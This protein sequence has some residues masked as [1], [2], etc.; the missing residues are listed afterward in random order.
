MT[1]PPEFPK[2]PDAG[3]GKQR[4]SNQVKPLLRMLPESWLSRPSHTRLGRWLR[5]TVLVWF[6][7]VNR[8]GCPVV[9]VVIALSDHPLARRPCP[10]GISQTRLPTARFRVSKVA[11]P[12][13]HARQSAIWARGN[14]LD[15]HASDSV[16]PNVYS[17]CRLSPRLVC[18][19]YR[20]MSCSEEVL[21]A[22]VAQYTT[23][24]FGQGL[25]FVAQN[26][27]LLGRHC[28]RSVRTGNRCPLDPK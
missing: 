18:R 14:R 22:L 21:P 12:L 6:G 2:K 13:S 16:L 27:L 24:Y 7:P 28:E 20:A 23:P 3:T 5:N 8:T 15:S 19:A 10:Y 11:G 9:N 26:R 4:E 17:K 1:V 25:A